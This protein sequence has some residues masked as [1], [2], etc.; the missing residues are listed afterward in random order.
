[1]IAERIKELEQDRAALLEALEIASAQLT[2]AAMYMPSGLGR[3]M[4]LAA[5]DKYDEIVRDVK[6]RMA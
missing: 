6:A 2:E 5:T 3:D 4:F 1:M